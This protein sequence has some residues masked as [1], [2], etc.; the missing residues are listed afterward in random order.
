M[1]PSPAVSADV[2]R[3]NMSLVLRSL[4]DHEPCA[5]SEIRART[6]LVSGTVTT[7]TEELAAR[8]LVQETGSVS[9][10]G[11][12]RPRRL[13]RTV[14]QRVRTVAVQLSSG[15]VMGEV[16]DLAGQVLWAKTDEH[17]TAAGDI[18]ELVARAGRMLDAA[19]ETAEDDPRVHVPAPVVVVPG[20]LRSDATVV[21]SLELGLGQ[22]DLRTPLTRRLRRPRDLALMNTG[23]LGALSEYAAHPPDA[24]PHAMAYVNGLEGVGGT[25]L[26][27]G[28]FYGGAHG[29]A[30]ECGHITVDMNG[31]R[32]G[33]GARGCLDLYLGLTAI[34]TRVGL[35]T[36]DPARSLGE[37][38]DRLERA[39]PTA[40]EA[41][42]TA[43]RALAGAMATMASYTDLDLVVLG[44]VLPRLFPW[45]EPHLDELVT[46]RSRVT[47]EFNPKVALA[48]YGKEAPRRGAWLHSRGLVLDDPSRVPYV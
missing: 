26:L 41:L 38:V 4:A 44:G 8:G 24:R 33:C 37:L 28:D 7:M 47:P 17:G 6:G 5:R 42:D 34:L 35:P 18:D 46:A 36:E 29:L 13:L 15:S 11:R 40:C 10:G 43:G 14:P 32:C 31:P 9:G 3:H 16:R 30:G 48:R 22:T 12:G 27:D 21:A 39:E 20:L 45:L 25:V 23:R 2:G 1:P 19:I